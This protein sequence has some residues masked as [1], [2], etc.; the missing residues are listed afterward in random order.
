M[1]ATE[2]PEDPIQCPLCEFGLTDEPDEYAP[3]VLDLLEQYYTASAYSDRAIHDAV[4]HLISRCQSRLYEAGFLPEN[5]GISVKSASHWR[6]E[7]RAAADTAE[8][9]ALVG[10]AL[11]VCFLFDLVYMPLPADC[12][13]WGDV[14]EAQE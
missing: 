9:D 11:E 12:N 7:R 5:T 13:S 10:D 3:V 1:A 6:S 14:Q 4:R 2:L 8:F